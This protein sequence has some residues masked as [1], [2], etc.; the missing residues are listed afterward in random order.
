MLKK[1]LL[2][3]TCSALLSAVLTPALAASSYYLLVPANAGAGA[4]VP[5]PEPPIFVNLSGAALPKGM[6]REDYSESLQP[7][8]AVTGDEAFDAA[9]VR[10]SVADGT[11]P[12]GLALD[13]AT[14]V[15]AGTPTTK[16]TVPASFTVLATYKGQ[17]GQA[18]Y[19]I[20]VGEVILRVTQIVGGLSHTC[21][22][23]AEG[24]A[25]CWGYNNNGQLGDGSTNQRTTPVQVAGLTSGV[26]SIA[27]GQRHSCAVHAGV[28]KCWG[29]NSENQ[30]GDGTTTERRSPQ[31]VINTLMTAPVSVYTYN[32][33]TCATTS[34]GKAFCWGLNN[35]GQLGDTSTTNRSSPVAM[36]LMA[37]VSVKQLALG[38][39]HT[40]ALTTANQTYCWGKNDRGQLGNGT[41]ADN[42]ARG[43]AIEG[44][45][46]IASGSIH[47]CG[48]TG[49][50]G[51]SCWGGN[52][53]GQVGDG[54]MVVKPR[55]TIISSI[56]GVQQ[57]R[58]G[59]LH[60]CALTT[61]GAI[62]CW[63][64]N[65]SKQ[66]GDASAPYLVAPKQMVSSG[67]STLAAGGNHSCAVLEGYAKCWGLNANG[68]LGNNTTN[69][70][71]TPVN[72]PA[73]D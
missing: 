54:T 33:H 67:A 39:Q 2:S 70:S 36:T 47:V 13:A 64:A 72:I 69:T 29:Y 15:V 28:A 45:T 24:A 59:D 40:C 27:A 55:P 58:A 12:A 61:G 1:K 20:E 48:I 51:L 66:A 63:G 68:Q 19:T 8:L 30:L 32:A 16:T 31:P 37:D 41:T 44:F 23:T 26:T 65:A 73:L 11:L 21:A 5:E 35:F 4:S 71:A 46:S 56:A 6:V 60:T 18:V 14:G 17:D 43:N 50:G 38:M 57:V 42:R 34:D 25:K 62:S 53:H 49:A 10:W 7:Y 9:G 22:I 52:T 3:L